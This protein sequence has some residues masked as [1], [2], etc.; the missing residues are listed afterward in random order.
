MSSSFAAQDF[1]PDELDAAIY[2]C[3]QRNKQNINI[4]VKHSHQ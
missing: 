4:V 3:L 2:S 1:N